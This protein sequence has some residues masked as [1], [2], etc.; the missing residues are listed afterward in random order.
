MVRTAS[1]LLACLEPVKVFHLLGLFLLGRLHELFGQRLLA[2]GA[3]D[4]D[5]AILIHF[6]L[7][8][9]QL[10]RSLQAIAMAI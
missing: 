3:D 9:L 2:L 1:P 6:V 8:L 10:S 5:K 4:R 7:D